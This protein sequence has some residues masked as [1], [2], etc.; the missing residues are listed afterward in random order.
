[1]DKKFEFLTEKQAMT[2]LGKK[3][4]W[5]H[6]MKKRGLRFYK[7]KGTGTVWYKE[8]DLISFIQDGAS[9]SK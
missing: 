1:M 2:M 8:E 6:V 7:P 9:N 3:R 5:F 4:T